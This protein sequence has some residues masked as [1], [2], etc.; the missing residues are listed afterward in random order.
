MLIL[1]INGSERAVEEEDAMRHEQHDAAAVLLRDGEIIAAIEEERLDRLK[2]SNCFPVNAIRA[3][4]E[5]A[6]ITLPQVDRIAVNWQAASIAFMRR[7]AFLADASR[8]VTADA[9][10]SLATSFVRHFGV[11]IAERLRFCPHHVAHAWSSYGVAGFS[12]ALIL[13]LDCWGDSSSGMILT[14]KGRTLR[15]LRTLS[16]GKSLGSIYIHVIQLLGFYVFD[17]YKAMGLAPYGD[18]TRYADLFQ[19]GYRLL[20]DGE[21]EVDPFSRWLERFSNAG[22]LQ[23][24]RRRD[25]PITVVH[26]DIAASL[27]AMLEEIVL[28]VLKHFADVTQLRSLCLAGGVAHNCSMNG[29]ILR[30]G[31]FEHVF[32][33][34]A[35]HDAGGAL[36][37]ALSICFAEDGKAN[38]APMRTVYLGRGIGDAAALGKTLSRWSQVITVSPSNEIG[39]L[40][41]GLLAEGKVV[42]W[43]QGRSEFGP[44]ALGNRSILADPRP[45]SNRDRINAMV[46]RREG[47]RPFAPSVLEEWA[48]EYFDLPTTEASLGFMTYVVPVKSHHR[49]N[50]GAITH[51]NGTARIHVVSREVNPHFWQL[52]ESFR[53]ATGVP[54]LLN[55]S[56][57]NNAEPIVDSI[58]DA[59]ACFLTTSIDVLVIGNCVVQ[60]RESKP[61]EA[62]WTILHAS[63][64]PSCCVQKG[65]LRNDPP[66]AEHRVVSIKR[67]VYSQRSRAI[68]PDTFRIVSECDGQHSVAELFEK[69]PPRT[70]ESHGEILREIFG[71]WQDRFL[72]LAPVARNGI[73]DG[74]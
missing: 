67:S 73:R 56:F 31:L 7:R 63:L 58:D 39:E 62:L 23:K 19:A 54:M 71:L 1:G 53:V 3:C 33:Q 44:R 24:A 14:G 22:L 46:K 18:P 6:D 41:A 36:G 74:H 30:E 60:R 48:H 34:P 69:Y 70:C 49:A 61:S 72:R 59:V 13:T 11:D 66:S 16:L 64:A 42:G 20:P 55:T 9:H 10:T 50:L 26:K 2:H 15:Q 17:E 4:L 35:A 43:V 40:T 52:I 27:Q 8:P 29:R 25:E 5:I 38:T 12:E 65:R 57:N 47:F 37:A 28:H 21:Y 32:V 68:S 51:V 45:V